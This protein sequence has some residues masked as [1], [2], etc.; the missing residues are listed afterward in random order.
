MIVIN[1]LARRGR[2][3]GYPKSKRLHNDDAE[4][5]MNSKCEFCQPAIPR[6]IT[7]RE[8][9]GEEGWEGGRRRGGGR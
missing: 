1:H 9:P 3:R 5:K 4:I 8:P 7:T 6:I 2:A